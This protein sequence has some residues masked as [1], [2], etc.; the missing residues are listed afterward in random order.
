MK[1]AVTLNTGYEMPLVGFGTYM[2]TNPIDDEEAVITAVKNGYRL[3]D[4]AQAYK[5]EEIIG[6]ALKQCPVPREDIFV[7][8]KIWFTDFSGNK[9]RKSLE[10]S[11]RKLDLDYID[12]VLLHW[13][14]NDV[15]RAWRSLEQAVNN[16]LVPSACRT[17]C[18]VNS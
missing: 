15:Y 8:T 1:P 16:G 3:I 7:T 6:K 18:R 10:N 14:Y 4:T 17:S 13:P 9:C 5:N 2:L 12:L 11:L